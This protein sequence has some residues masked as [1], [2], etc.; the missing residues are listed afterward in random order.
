M[1]FFQ[2]SGSAECVI[3]FME[4][5]LKNYHRPK[6]GQFQTVEELIKE[7]V[8]LEINFALKQNLVL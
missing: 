8:K 7:V 4:Y 1:C 6:T 2:M 3:L 5:E